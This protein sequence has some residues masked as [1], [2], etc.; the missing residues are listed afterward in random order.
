M[1]RFPK[2]RFIPVAGK[3]GVANLMT[4][5]AKD[6]DA[7]AYHYEA[8]GKSIALVYFGKGAKPAD[9]RVWRDLDKR[10]AHTAAMFRARAVQMQLA[11]SVRAERSSFGN[12]CKIGDLFYDSWGYE[13]TNVNWY[14]VIELRG[15]SVVV[16]EICQAKK[17]TGHMAGKCVPLPGQFLDRAEPKRCLVQ[18]GYQGKPR[19]KV[20]AHRHARFVE[21]V[22]IGGVPTYDGVYFSEYA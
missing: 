2:E 5:R 7:V 20:D 11:A 3:H 4:I 9:H 6:S 14:E 13:Q 16:R 18:P 12:P 22:M 8:N 1:R 19:I 10:N 17:Y 21:P 15:K